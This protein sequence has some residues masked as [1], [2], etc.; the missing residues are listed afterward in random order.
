LNEENE[1]GS[2]IYIEFIEKGLTSIYQLGD[3]MV[4]KPLKHEI[5]R[6]YYDFV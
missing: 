3:V 1:Y 2:K 4:N 6:R 5:R